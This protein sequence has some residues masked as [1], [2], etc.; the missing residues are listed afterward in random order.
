MVSKII[1]MSASWCMPCKIYAR[2]FEEIK[3]EEKYKDIV[4]EE[5][6]VDED[7]DLALEY[8]V[9]NVPT[10]IILDEDNIVL[11]KIGGNMPK[12]VLEEKIDEFLKND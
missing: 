6:D 8:N 3:K 4:F 5:H 10:T 2:T 1:K 12:R 11:T 7:E 9:R